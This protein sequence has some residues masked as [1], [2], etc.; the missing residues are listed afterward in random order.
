MIP[1]NYAEEEVFD[2]IKKQCTK[3]EVPYFMP[4]HL[5][6]DRKGAYLIPDI[7]L[8]NGCRKLGIRPQTCIEVKANLRY[9]TFDRMRSMSDVIKDNFQNEKLHLILVTMEP[10]DFLSSV[11][12]ALKSR[13]IEIVYFDDWLNKAGLSSTDG[14]NHQ[15]EGNLSE[16]MKAAQKAFLSGPNT[17]FLGAGVSRSEGLPN[18]K[19][20]LIAIL[21]K[22]TDREIQ[23]KDFDALFKANGYSSIIMGRYIRN[24]YGDNSDTLEKDVHQIM[25]SQRTPFK[26]TSKTIQ[27]ICEAVQDNLDKVN[28]IIT[29]NYDDLIEQQFRNIG[30]DAASI[31]DT[32]EPDSRF[33]VYHVHGILD[34]EGLKSSKIVLSEDDYHEQYRRAFLWSNIEQLHALQNNNCFFLGLSMTDPNLR[35][36]LDFTKGEENSKK[37]RDH[38]CFAFMCRNEVAEGIK[39][40]KQQF[41]NEQKSILE[42]LGVRVIWYDRHDQLPGLLERLYKS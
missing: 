14:N 38:H 24:L 16:D 31:F 15:L 9:D 25:Y 21:R 36:L 1:Y 26:I 35:R 40:N 22:V 7:Y 37:Q 29:Y 23:E 3:G 4:Y 39:E 11:Y 30:I 41:L 33:P 42:S 27:M 6:G 17:F 19:G 12:P 18:W 32:H 20:L 13:D 28:S 8:P 10:V 5:L 34:Q 2:F